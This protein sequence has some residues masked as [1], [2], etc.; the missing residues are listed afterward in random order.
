MLIKHFITLTIFFTLFYT[1]TSRLEFT[2]DTMIATLLPVSLIRGEGFGLEKIYPT[3]YKINPSK[4]NN[5]GL[6]Y[7]V[8]KANNRLFSVFPVFSSVISTPIYFFPVIFKKITTDNIET[9]IQLLYALGKT[10]ASFFSA[11]S[12]GLVYL[13][14]KEFLKTKKALLIT[15]FYA[16]GTTTFSLSSQSL[17]Q[18]AASQ[19]FL[20]ATIY[21]FVKGQRYRQA[22]PL[23]GLFLGFATI[24]RFSIA[25]IALLFTCYFIIFERKWFLRFIIFTLPSLIF[26]IWYQLTYPG[27]LFFYKYEGVGQIVSIQNPLTGLL[28]LL[29]SPNK[30]ILIYSPIFFFSILGIILAWVKKNR[31]FIFFSSTIIIYLLFI[32]SWSIWHGGWSYGPRTLAEITPFT[33]VLLIPVLQNRKIWRN[34]FFK[35]MFI[36]AGVISFF[37][38]FLGVSTANI[39]WFVEQT[40]NLTIE[41]SHQAHFLWNWK[42][43]EIY[44]FFLK[45]GGFSGIARI[46]SFELHLIGLNLMK[47]ITILLIFKLVYIWLKQTQKKTI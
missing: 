27:N 9:N 30:G 23:C 41:E 36:L 37:I 46:F 13:A 1:G 43:P 15:I 6:P 22:L 18:C 20:S 24:S 8:I 4:I 34:Y 31:V 28:G 39:S 2:T 35:T 32:G 21:F 45:A 10:S 26:L 14:A 29:I 3:A 17:W 44:H 16:L 12:V 38:H 42:Y 25:V 5:N 11:V 7:Y 40:R 47:G 19:M 33:T